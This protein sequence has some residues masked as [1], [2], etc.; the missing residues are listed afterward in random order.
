MDY[1][2]IAYMKAQDLARRM[3]SQA[4]RENLVHLR[5]EGVSLPSLGENVF[6]FFSPAAQTVSL[7]TDLSY[8]ANGRGQTETVIKINGLAAGKVLTQ[9]TS[10]GTA[11]MRHAANANAAKGANIVKVIPKSGVTL[12]GSIALTVR[13][14]GLSAFGGGAACFYSPETGYYSLVGNG[15]LAVYESSQLTNP[16]ALTT[17][18]RNI[19]KAVFCVSSGKKALLLE[20]GKLV[21]ADFDNFVFSGETS[22]LENVADFGVFSGGDAFIVKGG[23][24]YSAKLAFSPKTAGQPIRCDT[25]G[26][27]K[28]VLCFQGGGKSYVLCQG[29]GSAELYTYQSGALEKAGEFALSGGT[30]A[31]VSGQDVKILAVAGGTVMEWTVNL[32][33]SEALR[34]PVALSNAA[35]YGASGIC[36]LLGDKLTII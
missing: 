4:G 9:V 21:L 27:I 18:A 13:G 31:K 14:R 25:K 32:V 2:K 23:Y 28:K 15:T 19:T 12:T 30:D 20:D 1:G 8:A 22:V 5:R 3:G 10:Y 34:A 26:G 35:C 33:S 36:V 7:E 16:R 29:G 24:L 17:G 11:F 6:T